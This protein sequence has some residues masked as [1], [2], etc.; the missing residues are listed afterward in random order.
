MNK[1][2]EIKQDLKDRS[3][4]VIEIEKIEEDDMEF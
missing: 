3:I 4:E 1:I 2:E